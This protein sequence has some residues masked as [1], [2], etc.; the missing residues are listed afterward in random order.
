MS[1]EQSERREREYFK[2]YIGGSGWFAGGVNACIFPSPK[3][4]LN[5]ER[6]YMDVFF[7]PVVAFILYC[8]VL[9]ERCGINVKLNNQTIILKTCST[10]AVSFAGRGRTALPFGSSV[11][12]LLYT[13]TGAGWNMA[14]P[15][16]VPWAY[17][18]QGSC[19]RLRGFLKN[20]NAWDD[21]P[22]SRLWPTSIWL[23]QSFRVR[24]GP[25]L[26]W[27]WV[28]NYELTIGE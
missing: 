4:P 16:L 14:L 28:K 20:F 22:R 21:V 15:F 8:A 13:A 23:L 26:I 1:Q 11:H 12:A 3:G 10:F 2:P 7:F 9:W 5:W 27:R 18:S 19:Q 24:P 25:H 6:S 17:W